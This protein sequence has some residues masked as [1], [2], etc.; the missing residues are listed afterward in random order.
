MQ[1][2]PASNN[3]LCAPTAAVCIPH[4]H[5][6]LPSA[7]GGAGRDEGGEVDGVG[8]H[9][10]VVVPHGLEH[11]QRLLPQ[12]CL[13]AHVQQ[14]RECGRLWLECR[15]AYH[16][17]HLPGACMAEHRIHEYLVTI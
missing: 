4:L 12:L 6:F 5:G 11:L 7:G 16:A 10:R 2:A 3:F 1:Q 9:S 8:A 17:C 14:R 15:A 13:G